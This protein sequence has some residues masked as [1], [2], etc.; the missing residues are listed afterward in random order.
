MVIRSDGEKS[1]W[2]FLMR[3][4]NHPSLSGKLIAQFV[5]APSESHGTGGRFLTRHLR[6]LYEQGIN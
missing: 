2:T 3:H 4:A 5:F 1:P 6:D